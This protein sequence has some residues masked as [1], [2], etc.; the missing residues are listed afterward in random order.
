MSAQVIAMRTKLVSLPGWMWRLWQKKLV[1]F[2]VLS[3][4]AD[5]VGYSLVYW[6][7]SRGI[8]GNLLANEFV[9]K[10]M[11]PLGLFLNTYALAGRLWPKLSEFTKWLVYWFPSASLGAMCTTFVVLNF[12]FGSLETRAAAGLM[13]FPLDYTMKR[14]IIFARQSW[15]DNLL[16]KF[17]IVKRSRFA[18]K[19]AIAVMT[20]VR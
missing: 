19:L 5:V 17:M 13:M 4:A 15:L 6:L 16:Q 12:D 11:A 1:R 7:T 14:F 2:I 9:S 20:F 10:V 3:L 8:M 18:L